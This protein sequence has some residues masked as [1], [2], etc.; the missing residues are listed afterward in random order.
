MKK[1]TK[2][3]GNG[4]EARGSGGFQWMEVRLRLEGHII[5]LSLGE[6][7]EGGRGKGTSEDDAAAERMKAVAAESWWTPWHSA[8]E[9]ANGANPM[10][11]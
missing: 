10:W 4:V 9:V 2:H 6:G 5:S 1:H 8:A 11:G 7:R 3:G